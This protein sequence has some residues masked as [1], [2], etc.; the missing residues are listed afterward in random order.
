MSAPTVMG[1][2]E[3]DVRGVEAGPEI[4]KIGDEFL[5]SVVLISPLRLFES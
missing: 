2:V 3:V 1:V 5:V 4:R